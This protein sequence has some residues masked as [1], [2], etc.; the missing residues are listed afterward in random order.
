MEQSRMALNPLNVLR[1]VVLELESAGHKA[2]SLDALDKTLL[3]LSKHEATGSDKDFQLA[4][5]NALAAGARAEFEAR[6]RED[7]EFNR[8]AVESGRFALKSAML[9]NGGAAV[10]M[11]AF[12]GS[13]W[14]TEGVKAVALPLATAVWLFAAGVLATATASGIAYLTQYSFV[15]RWNVAEYLFNAFSILLVLGAYA[16]FAFGVTAAH[17]AFLGGLGS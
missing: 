13:L 16:L 2:I 1:N 3:D 9:V 6:R 15:H 12:I 11:L 8:F 5:Y 17:S 10:A 4:Y 14:Q 7:I